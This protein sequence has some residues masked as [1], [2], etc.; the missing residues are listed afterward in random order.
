MVLVLCGMAT[1]QERLAIGVVRIAKGFGLIQREAWERVLSD[2]EFG[3]AYYTRWEFPKS[4]KW[5]LMLTGRW[6]HWLVSCR[7]HGCSNEGMVVVVRGEAQAS[8]GWVLLGG[9]NS[10]VGLCPEH[11]KEARLRQRFGGT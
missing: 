7:H 11:V 8:K 6:P 4:T 1:L 5:S 3:R 2:P 9:T 10:H